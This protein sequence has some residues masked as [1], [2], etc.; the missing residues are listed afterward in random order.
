MFPFIIL[1][2]FCSF[3]AFLFTFVHFAA[4]FVI[5]CG[6][7]LSDSGEDSYFHKSLFGERSAIQ[8]MTVYF[9]GD[10]E[11]EI[12]IGWSDRAVM[13]IAWEIIK[14]YALF[15]SMAFIVIIPD[16]A[17]VRDAFRRPQKNKPAVLPAA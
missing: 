4:W 2:L 13:G 5:L 16:I 15:V 9:L 10:G 11:T 1:V 7:K 8:R 14:T 3:A 12:D 17:L 6:D